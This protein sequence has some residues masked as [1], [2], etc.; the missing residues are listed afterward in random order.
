MLGGIYGL[1][2]FNQDQLTTQKSVRQ[3]AKDASKPDIV[4]VEGNPQTY[5]DITER[6]ID[7]LGG[8]DG[9]PAVLGRLDEVEHQI[10]AAREPDPLVTRRRSRCWP[11]RPSSESGRGRPCARR[12]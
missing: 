10:R 5:G 7:E 1:S 8:I 6:A 4:V 12:S 2:W 3:V 9:T 11:T